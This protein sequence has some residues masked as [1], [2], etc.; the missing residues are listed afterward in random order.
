MSALD[1]LYEVEA[2]TLLPSA[3]STSGDRDQGDE[4]SVH[5]SSHSSRSTT[6]KR[7]VNSARKKDTA[8][9]GGS[10]RSSSAHASRSSR[11]GSTMDALA[12]S[13]MEESLPILN[14]HQLECAV[15]SVAML[16]LL[17][18]DQAVRLERCVEAV[19]FVYRFF[20]HPLHSFIYSFNQDYARFPYL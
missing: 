7:D 15:R 16:A 8:P 20:I 2:K 18:N 9:A 4:A 12:G 17:E 14:A 10:R 5:S 1:V 6:S 3:S 13:L 19:H 11:R